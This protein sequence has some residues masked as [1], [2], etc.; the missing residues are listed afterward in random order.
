M[1][2]NRFIGGHDIQSLSTTLKTLYMKNYIPIID[3][4]KE[5]ARY[6]SDVL[7]YNYE[8]TR[9]IDM[10][11]TNETFSNKPV[12]YALK[13]S[14]FYP[15][16]PKENLSSII[17]AMDKTNAYIFLDAEGSSNKAIEEYIYKTVINEHTGD[18]ILYKTYQMY[19]VDSLTEL[20]RDLDEAARLNKRLGIKLV[21]GAYH[22]TKDDALYQSKKQ[23]DNNYN[24]AIQLLASVNH[25]IC[26]ATH[27]KES[28]NIAL[29]CLKDKYT[30]YAQLY[31]M[32]D[33]LSTDLVTRQQRVFKYVPYGNFLDTYPY[34]LRRLV[35]NGHLLKHML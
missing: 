8:I 16:Y 4:A 19:R 3:Y 25:S 34:L 35:E 18:S 11:N 10:M 1:L 28:I 21:R 14:S 20:E 13:L 22:S 5:G 33:N 15:H 24:T 30:S 31:G 6:R 9:L 32:A 7:R 27:N 2:R 12:G 17:K 29:M 23:T 26:I